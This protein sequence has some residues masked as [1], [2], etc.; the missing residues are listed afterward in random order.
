MLF[1]SR[2]TDEHYTPV[3]PVCTLFK[4]SNF[5]VLI[6]VNNKIATKL[7]H[8]MSLR[9]HQCVISVTALLREPRS[10]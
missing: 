4:V 1:K 8:F 3:S 7:M 9:K 2:C 5:K 10:I 6:S